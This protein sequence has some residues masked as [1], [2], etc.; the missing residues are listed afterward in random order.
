MRSHTVQLEEIKSPAA[1][2]GF[3]EVFCFSV[4]MVKWFQTRGPEHRA[5]EGKRTET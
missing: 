1:L 4:K 3:L 5:V 2:C